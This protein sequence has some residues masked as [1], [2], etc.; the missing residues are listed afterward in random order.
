[1]TGRRI[2]QQLPERRVVH[3]DE[4]PCPYYDPREKPE[5]CGVMVDRRMRRDTGT[6]ASQYCTRHEA[7]VSRGATM[8]GAPVAANRWANINGHGGRR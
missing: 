3:R 8:N 2:E 7:I 1:V 4:S 6:R 5:R